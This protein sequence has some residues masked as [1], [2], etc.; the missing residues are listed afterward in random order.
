M[1][2]V[3]AVPEVQASDGTWWSFANFNLRILAKDV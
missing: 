2:E 3:W 1:P